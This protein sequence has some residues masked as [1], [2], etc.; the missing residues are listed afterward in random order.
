MSNPLRR[1]QRAGPVT[2]HRPFGAK[3]G[4]PWGHCAR[5][6]SKKNT[7]GSGSGVT[8]PAMVFKLVGSERPEILAA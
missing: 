2:R 4:K 3:S 5:T 8:A 7:K 6:L 1:A